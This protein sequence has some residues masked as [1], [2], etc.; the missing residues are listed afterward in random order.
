MHTCR[1]Y[2]IYIRTST[3]IIE[4]DE[5]RPPRM[6]P[7]R[8]QRRME[9]RDT[10]NAK[11]SPFSMGKRCIVR[12]IV[13][14]R[15]TASWIITELGRSSGDQPDDENPNPS[16]FHR[17]YLFV[18]SSISRVPVSMSMT[19]DRIDDAKRRRAKRK[20]SAEF[21]GRTG[22]NRNYLL[23]ARTHFQFFFCSFKTNGFVQR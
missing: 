14:L 11:V 10:L 16:G 23:S 22:L 19:P 17:I 1:Y 6:H 5:T 21:W 2:R 20:V 12:G 8:M 18:P 13:I 7:V 3:A 9:D 15:L 4:I